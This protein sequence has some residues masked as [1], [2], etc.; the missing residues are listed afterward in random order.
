MIA[1]DSCPDTYEAVEGHPESKEERIPAQRISAPSMAD[2]REYI[3]L[4]VVPG[5]KITADEICR[6]LS[7]YK[8]QER[9][10]IY[11]YI[12][13]LCG[14]GILKKD[15]YKHGGYR[16]VVE[17]ETYDLGGDISEDELNFNIALPLEL[18][19]LID[20]KTDQL[21]QVSGRYDAGKSSFL[22]QI[23][24]D[25]YPDNKVIFIVSEEWSLNAIKERM[26][27][28]SIPRPHPN[29]TVIP[30]KP[31]YEDMIP[32]GRWIVLIDYVRADQN[33]FETDST[34]PQKSQWR[35]CDIRYS[36]TSW[37]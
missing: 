36:E 9:K 18:H 7:C 35:Y 8:R 21:L 27:I 19:N 3:D 14:D 24:A 6:G 29:I 30:M 12:G 23:M 5:Q 34:N 1:F 17:V 4:C 13:R 37:P 16:R 22:F 20:L 32:K 26:D 2:L 11:T 33:P 28:L 10:A 31:G 25:N 15:D